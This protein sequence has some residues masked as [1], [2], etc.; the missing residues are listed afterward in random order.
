VNGCHLHRAERNGRISKDMLS[1]AMR[2]AH[3]VEMADKGDQKSRRML[4]QLRAYL[5]PE[6]Y[7]VVTAVVTTGMLS[8]GNQTDQIGKSAALGI[9]TLTLLVEFEEEREA[10]GLT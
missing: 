9:K 10:W 6:W 2:L 5:G 1:A 7:R 4:A 8:A 3:A